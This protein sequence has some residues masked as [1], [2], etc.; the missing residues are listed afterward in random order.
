MLAIAQRCGS[1]FG[2]CNEDDCCSE[3]GWCGTMPIYCESGCQAAFGQC[4]TTTTTTPSSSTSSSATQTPRSDGQCGPSFANVPCPSSQCCSEFG[5]C[6]TDDQHCGTGCL[7]QCSFTTTS[8]FAS[9]TAIIPTST[10][11]LTT[12]ASAS[13]TQTNIGYWPPQLE[14]ATNC[15]RQ[16]TVALTFD[17]GPDPVITAQVMAAAKAQTP[18]IPLLFFQIGENVD[19]NPDISA[20]V[21]N[22]GFSIGDHSYSHLSAIDLSDAEITQQASEA[23]SA[24]NAA[25][26]LN[27]RFFRPPVLRINLVW[28]IYT[29]CDDRLV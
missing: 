3:Y 18:Q 27:P 6:G 8:L 2:S 22:L 7:Y 23:Y 10:H 4:G 25:T 28:R 5:W 11:V 24:I 15:V 20:N 16:K 29:S 12:T 17:D 14:P 9:S 13:P 1:N 26:G 19:A 21:K